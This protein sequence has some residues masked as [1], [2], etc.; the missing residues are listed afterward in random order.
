MYLTEELTPQEVTVDIEAVDHM[1]GHKLL[2]FTVEFS[3]SDCAQ[4]RVSHLLL[5]VNVSAIVRTDAFALRHIQK[6]CFQHSMSLDGL[7]GKRVRFDL[8]LPR[9]P[10]LV[11]VFAG[12]YAVT[13]ATV[14][15]NGR[16]HQ[17]PSAVKSALRI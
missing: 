8:L 11:N 1:N 5:A 12:A 2:H 7:V 6:P 16:Q 3:L 9:L 13:A 10:E 14:D 4:G 15:K 17:A